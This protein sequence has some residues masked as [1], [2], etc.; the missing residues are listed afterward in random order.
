MNVA[1]I[2]VRGGS[3][4]IPLKNIKPIC[5]KPLV[6]W[7]VKAGCAC[8]YIDR[9]YVATDSKEIRETVE[10]FRE[11]EEAELFAK[12][13]VIGRSEE[14][15]SDTASTESAMLEFAQSYDFDNCVLIQA[16]SPLLQAED[17]NRGFQIFEEPD[18]DSV[19]SVVRQKRFHWGTDANGYAHPTNYDVFHRPRRQEFDGY[20]V[21]NGA[22]YITSKA[23][24]S[25]TKNRVSGRIR[26]VEM[27]EDS[28]FEI[29]EPSD[30]IIIE[31][32]MKKGRELSRA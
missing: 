25:E 3:K 21:E 22:F 31:A 5:G 10:A 28:F 24:L 30:W 7:T 9:V 16:T 17:L 20:L 4:S 6:Y 1:F 14:S 23:A 11:G 32:L 12:C 29:D 15:A 27:N 19:L 8:K 13:E 18:T 2:P 26:V